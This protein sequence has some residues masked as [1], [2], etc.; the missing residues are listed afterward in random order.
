MTEKPQKR[1][2]TKPQKA[3]PP[4]K[5]LK[6]NIASLEEWSSKDPFIEVFNQL[7]ISNYKDRTIAQ[8]RTAKA[9]QNL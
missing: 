1:K 6:A 9:A 8:K 4:S 2:S 3:K 5:K 7:I